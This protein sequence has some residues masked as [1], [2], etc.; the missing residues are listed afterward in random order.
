MKQCTKCGET[1][2]LD[3]FG[4]TGLS[5]KTGEQLYRSDCNSC[6][7]EY[8]KKKYRENK[9]YRLKAIERSKR[10]WREQPERAREVEK[11]RR[12]NYSRG[13]YLITNN[14]TGRVYVGS[15]VAIEERWRNH[16]SKLDRGKHWSEQFQLD[17]NAHGKDSFTFKLISES[18]ADAQELRLQEIEVIKKFITEGVELYNKAHNAQNKKAL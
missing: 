6:R 14:V 15:S 12:E 2:S 9:E 10:F 13:V 5:K 3:S 8:F 18:Q 11:K 7:S 4:K 1:K 17:Y 16:R